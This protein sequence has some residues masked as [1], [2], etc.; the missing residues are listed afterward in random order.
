MISR[1][2]LASVAAML[3]LTIPANAASTTPQDPGVPSISFFADKAY[4]ESVTWSAK[5]H[6][7]IIGSVKHGDVGKV[8]P[9]GTYTPFINDKRL[10]SSAGLLIDDT[11]NILWVTNSDPGAGD[12]TQAAT[13]GKL[14][15]VAS[16]NASTGAPL[17]YYD[18]GGLSAGSHFA[19]DV[20][21]DAEGN[22]YVTDSFAPV[23]YRIGTDRKPSIFSQN[24]LFKTDEG[25]NLNGIVWHEDG[26]LL[27]GKYNSGELFRVNISEPG[28]VEKVRLPEALTGADGFTL[29]DK[30]HLIV[31][32]NAGADRTVEL[33]STDGWKSAKIARERKSLT[34]MP[35]A[36]TKVGKGI[37]VLNSRLDTLFDP[38]AEKVSDY[39]LQKFN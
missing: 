19:N 36:S 22:L 18:L 31:V 3:A 37:Y 17:A 6:T 14:A 38:K 5:Q 2:H 39:V 34:S 33:V 13:Q 26:Y 28:K 20:T 10:V 8:T 27:V 23:I 30:Q 29:V 21:L 12:R 35:T 1:S 7:F 32:Q 16:Y 15:G 24:P 25:F 11:R 4:P 9:E